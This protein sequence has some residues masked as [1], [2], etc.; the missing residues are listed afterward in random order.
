M[1][2]FYPSSLSAQET[3]SNFTGQG[4]LFPLGTVIMLHI[5]LNDMPE[6]GP[7]NTSAMLGLGS[8]H[9]IKILFSSKQVNLGRAGLV[10]TAQKS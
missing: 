8:D 4:N 3:S 10:E 1:R 7:A 5:A 9:S 6:A 2:F